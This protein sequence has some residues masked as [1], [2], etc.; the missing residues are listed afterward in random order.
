MVMQSEEGEGEEG[1]PRRKVRREERRRE[2]M[3]MTPEK[4]ERGGTEGGIV[5]T[6]NEEDA[7]VEV[8]QRGKR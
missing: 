2:G 6:K 8:H 7:L 4:K 1:K 3:H 5:D